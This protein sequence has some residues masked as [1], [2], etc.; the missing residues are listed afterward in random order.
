M[1]EA[2]TS[3]WTRETQFWRRWILRFL[4]EFCDE[5]SNCSLPGNH[6]TRKGYVWFRATHENGRGKLSFDVTGSKRSLDFSCPIHHAVKKRDSDE[7]SSTSDSTQ[8]FHVNELVKSL[9][10]LELEVEIENATR[11]QFQPSEGSDANN[12]SNTIFEEVNH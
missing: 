6:R 12:S 1:V 5:G 7:L 8:G 11:L 10:E 4:R 2:D 3:E 9:F